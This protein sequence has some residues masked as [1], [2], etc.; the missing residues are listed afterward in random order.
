MVNCCK[1][2]LNILYLFFVFF[3]CNDR[4]AIL[5]VF[6]RN[7]VRCKATDTHTRVCIYVLCGSKHG[8]THRHSHGQH[9]CEYHYNNNNKKVKQQEL[10]ASI[11]AFAA[12]QRSRAFVRDPELLHSP[13]ANV[14][15]A[16]SICLVLDEN[17]QLQRKSVENGKY[18]EAKKTNTP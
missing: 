2:Q 17:L 10:L 13:A 7:F 4:L 5:S 11:C 12:M 15:N 18:S 8:L 6:P 3:F 16:T 1:Q 14:D 9:C